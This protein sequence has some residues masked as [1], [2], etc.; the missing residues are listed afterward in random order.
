MGMMGPL[1]SLHMYY[2]NKG[3]LMSSNN[4]I[5]IVNFLK[6]MN[7]IFSINVFRLTVFH[8]RWI[9]LMLLTFSYNASEYY[10]DHFVMKQF[11][12]LSYSKVITYWFI[13]SN[14]PNILWKIFNVS[15]YKFY[16]DPE[17]KDY[18]KAYTIHKSLTQNL[19]FLY[20]HNSPR[21]CKIERINL[22]TIICSYS[23]NEI[24]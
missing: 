1:S 9:N 3:Q 15:H 14:Y 20:I 16:D 6:I 8:Y 10:S 13:F 24:H 19:Y 22:I 23:D 12:F 17:R 4:L 2:W 21:Q 11:F 18:I 5:Y 7:F